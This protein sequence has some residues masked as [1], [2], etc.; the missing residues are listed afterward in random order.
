MSLERFKIAQ[1]SDHAGFEVALEELHAGRK[2]SHWIWYIFP[3]LAALGRSTTAKHYGLADLKEA[4]AYLKDPLLR[5]RLWRAIDAVAAQLAQGVPLPE[6]MGGTTDSLK[7]V[8]S[9][10]LF[11]LA[12]R[13]LRETEG[14]ASDEVARLS[15]LCATVLEAAAQQGYP[16]CATT[17]TEVQR[18]QSHTDAPGARA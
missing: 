17:L 4:C 10:T 3:Q 8:S 16:R 11:E 5:G 7:L 15:E 18:K 12:A 2:T 9:L 1:A 13:K 6:L 14:E